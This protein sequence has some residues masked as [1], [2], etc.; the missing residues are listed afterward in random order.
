MIFDARRRR[1]PVVDASGVITVVHQ[2]HDYSHLPGGRSHHRH[3]ES[4]RNVS[5][6]GGREVIFRLEDADW[7]FVEGRL[8]RKS[9]RDWHYPRKWEADLIAALGPGKAARW[10]RAVFRRLPGGQGAIGAR[11][12]RA[13]VDDNGGPE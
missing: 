12:R 9:L 8:A 4:L 13:E 5:V 3:P 7:H 11:G 6:A 10:V 2:N 1:I